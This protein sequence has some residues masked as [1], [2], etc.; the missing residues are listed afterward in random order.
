MV[1]S[2]FN[3]AFNPVLPPRLRFGI[4]HNLRIFWLLLIIA[5][6]F[7]ACATLPEPG[8]KTVTYSHDPHPDSRLSVVTRN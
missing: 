7:L 1:R 8:M 4:V 3:V 6:V 2:K 5:W